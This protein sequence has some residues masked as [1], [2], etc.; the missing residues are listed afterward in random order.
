MVVSDL[1]TLASRALIERTQE[2]GY[3]IAKTG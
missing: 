1:A 3:V 2:L